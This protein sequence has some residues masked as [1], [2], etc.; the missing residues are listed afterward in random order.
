MKT[1]DSKTISVCFEARVGGNKVQLGTFASIKDK[2]FWKGKKNVIHWGIFPVG[3]KIEPWVIAHDVL[4]ASGYV[5][6]HLL[7]KERFHLWD[8]RSDLWLNMNEEP[9]G[10]MW[11]D[12]SETPPARI[13]QVILEAVLKSKPN[14]DLCQMDWYILVEDRRRRRGDNM[15]RKGGWRES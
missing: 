5:I 3:G 12:L 4:L 1:W 11:R 14:Q 2:V 13:L 8:C 10:S 9:L 7:N 15:L 6:R